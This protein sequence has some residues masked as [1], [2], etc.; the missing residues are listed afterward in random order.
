MKAT[1]KR[2]RRSYTPTGGERVAVSMENVSSMELFRRPD[3]RYFKVLYD[4]GLTVPVGECHGIAGENRFELQLLA[5]IIGNVK[6]HESGR[7]SLMEIGMMRQKRRI[8]PHVYYIND[9]KVLFEH[10]H[11]L[12]YLMFASEHAP[13]KPEV[14]QA[15][16]LKLLL[17]TGLYPF[18]LTYIRSLSAAEY[19]LVC[20]L[21]AYASK[22]VLVVMDFSAITVPQELMEP[23][24]ALMREMTAAGKTVVLT[25]A[26]CELIQKACTHA[27]FL[28][29][30][31][32]V[33]S[34]QIDA[35][36]KAYDKHV[37]SVATSAPERAV[38][39]LQ[40]AFPRLRA[41]RTEQGVSLY[42]EHAVAVSAAAEALERA[43]VAFGEIRI[44]AP[45]LAEA[46]RE[47]KRTL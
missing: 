27:S 42:G 10:M 47:V 34:G 43:N 15:D 8:L 35:L 6:P 16:W 31:T 44:P 13:G 29:D 40:A 45:S 11:V 39:A 28:V 37:L 46:F 24:A 17:K 32:I 38:S 33:K 19:A 41:E 7:C 3:G 2:K 14:K 26:S 21:L 18:T 36:C 5:E 9:Q 25:N 1:A 12:G 4:I 22:A 30:G 20:A 23:F